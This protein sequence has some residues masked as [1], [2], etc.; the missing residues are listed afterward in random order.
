MTIHQIIS[1]ALREDIG[2]GDHTSLST[3][4][5]NASG[6]ARLL[7]K[8]DG[9]LAGVDVALEVFRQV[10][11]DIR[12][13][14]FIQD[15]N[16]VKKGDIVFEVSGRSISLLTAE[17]TVLNFM[18]RMSG[19]A[20]QTHKMVSKLE[21]LHTRILDTR[22]TTPVLRELEKMAVRIG[23]GCNHRFGLYDMILIKDNHVDFAGGIANAIDAALKYLDE[24]KLNLKIEIEVRNLDEL[25]QVLD[26]GG[27]D[28][29]MLDNFGYDDLHKAVKMVDG[30]YETEASGGI[31]GETIRKYAEC[32]VDFVSVGALT[33]HISSL[34]LSLKAVKE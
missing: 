10:D 28:R 21:G 3:I 6:K 33:H 29:I 19:I 11:P 34:D 31:T 14:V 24:K 2:S 22:K 12:V 13:D 1:E 4:P 16:P 32:G 20:T 5:G 25:Q 9:I 27:V 23:G 30:N 26:R 18:Q 8:E 7:V 17:R 15:G